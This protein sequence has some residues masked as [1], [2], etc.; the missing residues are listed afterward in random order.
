MNVSLLSCSLAVAVF[1]TGIPALA[2]DNS[3]QTKKD[4]DRFGKLALPPAP[5][6]VTPSGTPTL[7]SRASA[8][9]SVLRGEDLETLGVRTFTDALRIIPGLE[10]QK[11]SSTESSVSLR[12]YTAGSA[13]SQGVF[14]LVNGRQVYN[15][16][17][18]S[19]FWENL[20]V[21][22][23]EIKSIEVV[24][25]PGSFLY[26]P[27]AM[28]G[29]I[30][31]QTRT[32]LE[33]F[34]DADK[35]AHEILFHAEG[36]T[37]QSNSESLIFVHHEG[38]SALKVK[39]AHDD[40]A[41]FEGGGDTR[42]KS[43]F[44]AAF[45]TRLAPDQR[46][47]LTAGASRQDFDTLI[48]RTP[49][50]P[51]PAP[52]IPHSTFRTHGNEFYSQGLYVLGDA[53]TEKS[54]SRV[55]VQ[56]D[57]NHFDAAGVPDPPYIPF[58][59]YLDTTDLDLQY[60]ISPLER[61]AVTAGTGIRY[62][63]FTTDHSDVSLGRHATWLAWLFIQDEVELVQ[64]ELFLTAGARLDQHSTA[65]NSIAPRVAL[66]WQFDYEDA[67]GDIPAKAQSIRATA[68]SGFRDPSLRDLWFNMPLQGGGTIGSNRD[69]KPEELKSFE[70]GYWGRPTDWIQL[71]A[72]VYY[73]RGDRLVAFQQ[74]V[75]GVFARQN[76]GHEDAYGVEMNLEA[77][78]TRD[79]FA[80]GNYSYEI[81]R[82]RDNSYVRIPGGPRNK[83]SA[84]VRVL[85]RKENAGLG[86]ML[87]ATFFDESEF[88]E[89]GGG[90]FLG[91]VPAYTL[92][93][94][95][96]WYPF[97]VGS[98]DGKVFL[99]GFNMLDHRHREHADGNAYGLIGVAGVEIGW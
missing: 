94:G 76:V 87:W 62:S 14:G 86:A 17:F 27:N 50:G 68:G 71:E 11:I 60:R 58:T 89:K 43:F 32:P 85:P 98:A 6:P 93:N 2:Q 7:I 15:E 37:Y 3:P 34:P 69:L 77:Q 54:S 16:F 84:G 49:T 48:P 55:T 44:E 99:E 95:R 12:S 52:I 47:L 24:R 64:K 31:I 10:I 28:H 19:V 96:V 65:G 57:W 33:Y 36:G 74:A 51:S 25:G 1:F 70:I 40:I 56:A 78:V 82:D 80:F 26:G 13:S 91:G 81:R 4:E 88:Q 59:V 97:R 67:K 79:V 18:G 42:N 41:E 30:N 38:E 92:L 5:D 72:S 83:A 35:E 9:V 45:E 29:L 8:T 22:L 20:P 90:P 73:N 66:V 61:H 39:V 75:P 21:T 23:N 63:T 53:T 46:L